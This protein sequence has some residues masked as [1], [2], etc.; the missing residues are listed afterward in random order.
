M[1]RSP[2]IPSLQLIFCSTGWAARGS[3]S[4]RFYFWIKRKGLAQGRGSVAELRVRG[5]RLNLLAANVHVTG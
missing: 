3:L 5:R 1:T 4:E 2:K